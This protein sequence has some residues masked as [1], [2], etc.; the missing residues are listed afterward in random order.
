MMEK[1]TD[2]VYTLL[3]MRG[4]NTS[5][6]VT[7]EGTIV[8]DTPMVPA[9]AKKWREEVQKYGEIRYVINNE[10]HNDHVAGNCWMGGTLVAHEGIREMAKRNS[11]EAFEGQM[12]WMAPDAVPL[13]KDFRYRLPDITFSQELKIYLGK[14]AIHIIPV[15]GHTPCQTAVFVP[16][17]KV[18]FTSDNVTMGMPIMI[19]AVPEEWLKSLKKLKTLDIDKIVPGHG[20]LCDKSALDVTYGNVEYITGELKNAIAKG[21][22]LQ[23]IQE[24]VTFAERFPLMPGD[25]MKMM[26]HESIAHM[27]EVLK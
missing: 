11:K 7:A 10:P 21:W 26:R 19:D 8:I 25:P 2:N 23:E 22:S 20:P 15:P 13:D 4:C 24:K 27:Y 18:V 17:E 16:E 9:D 1:V 5:F 3:N 6:V 12:K 14:H